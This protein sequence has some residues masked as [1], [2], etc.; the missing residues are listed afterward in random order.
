MSRPT[1][2]VLTLLVLWLIVL[3]PMI[4][5][6]VDEGAQ[7]R[8][9]RRFGRS[10]RLLNRRHAHTSAM[11]YSAGRIDEASYVAPRITGPRDE[12]F[13]PGSGRSP[14]PAGQEGQMH[15]GEMSDARRQ[16]MA[17][18]R[19]SLTILIAGS[20]ISLLLAFVAGG[21]M[22]VLLAAVFCL[23]L[24]GYVFFLRTQALRDRERHAWREERAH[25][26][27]PHHHEEFVEEEYFDEVPQT[28]VRIDDDNVD[29]H[30]LDT[31]DLTGVYNEADFRDLRE[32]RAS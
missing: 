24:G 25:Q 11:A 22:L 7:E 27:V 6:R 32:R 10:M 17:R 28:M 1:L 3:V 29:L 13:V 5:R 30:N 26:R 15:R 14:A 2:L 19:R 4:F 12:L 9:V 16:M 23:S 8:S 18:R 21:T 31:M 20:V